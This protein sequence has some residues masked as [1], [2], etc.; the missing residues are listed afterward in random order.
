VSDTEQKSDEKF[1]S[2]W[3]RLKRETAEAPPAV[4]AE[5]EKSAVQDGPPPELPPVE[6][7]T[8]DSDYKV[9][10]QPKVGED[11]RRA[12]L[13]KLFSDPHFNVMDGLDTYIDD[14]SISEPIPPEMLAQMRSAQKIFKW[15]RGES[16]EEEVPKEE[17]QP[18]QAEVNAAAVAQAELPQAAD[19]AVV[20]SALTPNA[21]PAELQPMVTAPQHDK[22]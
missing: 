16:D 15:A 19:Q 6:S 14:Y 7:L 3:S 11:V 17:V 10:F 1:L 8:K 20:P 4:P 22:P 9:F 13:K 5:S 12:A 18:A 2:R 21:E